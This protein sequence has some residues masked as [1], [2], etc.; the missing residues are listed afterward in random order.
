MRVNIPDFDV[1]IPDVDVKITDVDG[2]IT[3]FDIKI[4]DFDVKITDFD[5]KI[6]DFGQN[7]GAMLP[8]PVVSTRYSARSHI[9]MLV[10]HIQVKYNFHG[11]NNIKSFVAGY[12]RHYYS[13]RASDN[14][15]V[16][17]TSTASFTE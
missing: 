4:P 1:K 14:K 10:I 9:Y 13:K 15:Y 6:C 17:K 8:P 2:K 5:V 7:P 12:T 3:D 16:F 11:L